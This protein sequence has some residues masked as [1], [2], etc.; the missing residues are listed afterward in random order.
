VP[1]VR[2]EAENPPS[3]TAELLLVEIRQYLEPGSLVRA[4]VEEARIFV[5]LS[6]F[7]DRLLREDCLA[8]DP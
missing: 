4:V 1:N 7:L 6:E 3:E 5:E 2:D 8:L